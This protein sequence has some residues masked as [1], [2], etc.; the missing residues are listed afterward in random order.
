[1]DFEYTKRSVP[2]VMPEIT[3]DPDG[4]HVVGGGGRQP[5]VRLVKRGVGVIRLVPGEQG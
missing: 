1:M 2:L 3:D 5:G 4:G